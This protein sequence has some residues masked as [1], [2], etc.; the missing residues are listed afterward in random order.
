MGWML[1]GASLSIYSSLTSIF[2]ASLRL[3][4]VPSA[5]KNSNVTP[6]YKSGDAGLALN[7]RPISLLSLVSKIL[8][9]QV[10]DEIQQHLLEHDLLSDMQF[11]FRPGASTQEAIMAATKDW[12]WSLEKSESVA[13]VLFDL[14]K[15]FDSLPHPLILDSLVRVGIGREVLLWIRDYLSG[16]SQQ[17]VLRGIKSPT[18]PI[19]SGVPQGSILGPLLFIITIDS[20]SQVSISTLG[21]FSLFADDICYYRPV[22]QQ[23]DIIAVQNDVDLIYGWVK[24]KKLRLN[25]SK[26]K[27]M[28]I[29]KKRNPPNLNLNIDGVNIERV[30][31][32]R[33]LGVII[34]NDLTW[35]EHIAT[36]CGKAKRLI[37]F[38]Y[39]YFNQA[40]TS[41]LEHLYMTLVRPMLDYGCC[42]WSPYQAKY[43]DQLESVQTF[44]ARLA[45]KKWSSDSDSLRSLLGW[46]T[47]ASRRSYMKLCLCRRI[48]VG[49]S[50]I[51]DSTFSPHTSRTLRHI[52]SCPLYQPFVKTSYHLNSFFVSVIP[53]WNSIPDHVICASS[54][55]TFK[56]QL[57]K[58]FVV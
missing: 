39:R 55:L 26:T 48:L 22:S 45:T 9:H 56:R 33:L 16:R 44:A 37:G 3:G 58:L 35:S 25:A 43:V 18:V 38:L 24:F 14:S 4:R 15:A 13:C 49:D 52:N 7:Y 1:R 11:G 46:S 2:N 10:H 6:I 27:C 21:R 31:H 8:E 50:L 40:D 5:W 19:T 47:L 30:Q 57:K 53:L 28:L 51:P 23:E 34:S 41:C 54:V 42:V 17:V 36:V 32:F 20:I 12:H 29:S